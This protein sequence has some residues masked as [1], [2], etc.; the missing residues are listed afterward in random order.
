MLFS[1]VTTV[2][3]IWNTDMFHVQLKN[4]QKTELILEKNPK[5]SE[6]ILNA[7]M[8]IAQPCL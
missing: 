2:F 6:L 8:E 1:V 5:L 4:K 3:K 7:Q